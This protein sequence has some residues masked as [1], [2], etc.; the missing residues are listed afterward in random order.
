MCARI[1][2]KMVKFWY[3]GDDVSKRVR[4]FDMLSYKQKL[5]NDWS[6]E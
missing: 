4:D 5:M 3:V 6:F 2:E 1:M